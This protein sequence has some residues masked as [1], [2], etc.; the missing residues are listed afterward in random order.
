M[1]KR[2]CTKHP[3]RGRS[4]YPN[5]PG[6]FGPHGHL[7]DIEGRQG[8]RARQERRV[9]QTGVPWPTTA[10]ERADREAA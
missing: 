8:L 3:D 6:M 2:H 9:E 7:A 1:S 5:R 4:N 10:S